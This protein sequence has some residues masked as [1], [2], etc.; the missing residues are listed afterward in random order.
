MGTYWEVQDCGLLA[1]QMKPAFRPFPLTGPDDFD[2]TALY[3]I[4]RRLPAGEIALQQSGEV[5]APY[6]TPILEHL[7]PVLQSPRGAVPSSLV[8]NSAI[9]LGRVRAPRSI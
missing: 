1:P 7:V 3:H 4:R 8:D 9:T 6:A 5:M 2:P